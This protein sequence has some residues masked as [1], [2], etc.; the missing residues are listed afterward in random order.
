MP[1]QA[2]IQRWVP[3]F[4]GTNGKTRIRMSD[5]PR[6]RPE[7]RASAI[8]RILCGPGEAVTFPRLGRGLVLAP[9]QISRGMARRRRCHSSLVHA[10][11]RGRVAPFG[12]P[13][14]ASSSAPGRALPADRSNANGPPSAS[15]WQGSVVTPG[16]APAPPECEVTSLARG[17]RASRSRSPGGPARKALQGRISGLQAFALLRLRTVSGR[18]PSKSKARNLCRGIAAEI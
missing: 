4:A 13:S 18:R 9:R 3:A 12:A 2:G 8:A 7:I 6:S 11:I 1:A 17:R 5:S 10:P 14:A 16:G 15:S